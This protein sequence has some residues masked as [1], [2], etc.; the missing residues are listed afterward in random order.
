MGTAV[1]GYVSPISAA[2]LKA[3]PHAGYSQA[4]QFGQSGLENEYEHVP[5][6]HA[7]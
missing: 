6:G 7:G 4:S 1:L 3:N 5:E 2:E